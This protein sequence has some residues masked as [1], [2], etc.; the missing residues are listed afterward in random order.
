MKK[1]NSVVEVPS[2]ILQTWETAWRLA[3][4]DAS[5]LTIT[6][7]SEREATSLRQRCYSAR[8]K[9]VDA[10]YPR[11]LEYDKLEIRQEGPKLVFVLPSWIKNIRASLEEAGVGEEPA[12]NPAEPQETSD[13]LAKTI[14][15][16]YGGD[17][18]ETE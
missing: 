10:R 9:M 5:P 13:E 3:Q 18:G 1:Y 2:E 14:Q 8:R 15:G 16:I 6:L 17:K 12:E 4:G 11:S 7:S